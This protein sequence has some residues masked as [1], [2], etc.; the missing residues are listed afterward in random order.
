MIPVLDDVLYAGVPRSS[1]D[2]AGAKA[3]LQWFCSLPVQ[4]SLLTVNQSRRIGVF[5]ITDGFSALKSIDEKD[6]PPS[7]PCSWAISPWKTC[8]AFP[9]TLPDNWVKVRDAVVLALD[10]R[11]RLR[12]GDR[13]R[14][15][16]AW[17]T[18]RTPRRSEL[19]G[20]FSRRP[21]R[22]FH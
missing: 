6:L 14:W 4:Q 20:R 18:G 2:K 13:N 21:D 19:S 15:K 17:K 7:T 12:R 3:F 5:G 8:S 10:S 16:S 9:D 22:L 1:R 11:C